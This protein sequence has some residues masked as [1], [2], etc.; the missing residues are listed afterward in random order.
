MNKPEVEEYATYFIKRLGELV[1]SQKDYARS[2]G[3]TDA[4]INAVHARAFQ[5]LGRHAKVLE[6]KAGLN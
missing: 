3:L 5:L 2:V 4:E 6:E 1:R